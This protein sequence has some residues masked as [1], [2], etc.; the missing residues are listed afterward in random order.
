MFSQF[1]ETEKNALESCLLL[2]KDSQLRGQDVSISCGMYHM[3][4]VISTGKVLKME[5]DFPL[6]LIY[7]F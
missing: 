7:D 1:Y 2:G 5:N 3:E 4:F 6:N